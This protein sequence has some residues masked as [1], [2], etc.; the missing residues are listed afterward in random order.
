MSKPF[1]RHRKKRREKL[2]RLSAKLAHLAQKKPEQFDVELDE[3][4]RSWLEQIQ[5]RGRELRRK[6]GPPAGP[7]VFDLLQNIEQL[8]TSHPDIAQAISPSVREMLRHEC[9]KSVARAVDPRLYRLVS[10]YRS[11]RSSNANSKS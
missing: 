7:G 1:H 11:K 3:R 2:K 5:F 6:T 9:S 8:L 4:L 10:Q